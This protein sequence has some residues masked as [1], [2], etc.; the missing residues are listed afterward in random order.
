L[1]IVPAEAATIIARQISPAPSSAEPPLAGADFVPTEAEEPDS[2]LAVVFE[3]F[4]EDME[5]GS[6]SADD[7]D[8]ETHYNMGVAFKEMGLLEEAIGE[9]QKVCHALDHGHPFPHVLQVYT[10][11]AECLMNKGDSHG[12]V[13]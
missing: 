9:L 10:W 12:R 8:P 3:E 4:K 11:L 13:L 5:A 2:A 6:A 1:P 7:Q